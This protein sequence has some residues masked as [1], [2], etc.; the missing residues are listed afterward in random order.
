MDDAVNILAVFVNL[1]VQENFAGSLVLASELVAV[2]IDKAQIIGFEK[3]LAMQRRRAEHTLP[4]QTHR[5]VSFVGRAELPLIHAAAD[6][7]DFLSQ[8]ILAQS[9]SPGVYD[10]QFGNGNRFNSILASSL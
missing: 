3:A 6:F 4:V 7:T 10:S 5:N 8:L 2:E 1:Q 9:F